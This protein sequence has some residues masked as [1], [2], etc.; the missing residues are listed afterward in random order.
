MKKQPVT[1][2]KKQPT[3]HCEICGRRD[4]YLLGCARC[5]RLFGPCCN[6]MQDDGCVECEL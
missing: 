5:H 4:V 2:Q 1:K 3:G 6:S